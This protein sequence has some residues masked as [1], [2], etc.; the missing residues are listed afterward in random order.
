[1]AGREV[2]EAG[3]GGRE[4]L[5][6]APLPVPGS[7]RQTG[8]EGARVKDGWQ[9]LRAGDSDGWVFCGCLAGDLLEDGF[10]SG[11]YLLR[12]SSETWEGVASSTLNVSP[13]CLWKR[14]GHPAG[15]RQ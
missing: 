3:A 1:M 15:C 11:C 9:G 14:E 2:G 8:W 10:R 4:A 13:Y 12:P 7:L 5:P 6:G